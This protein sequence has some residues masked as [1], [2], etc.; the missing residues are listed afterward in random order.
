MRLALGPAELAALRVAAE[1]S[2]R[3]RAHLELHAGGA[4][5]A[6]QRFLVGMLPGSYVRAHRHV[7][8]HKLELTACLAGAFDLLLFDD[9]GALRERQRL[10]TDGAGLSLVQIPPNTWHSLIVREG[11][12]VLLEVKLGPYELASDKDFAD[13]APPEGS[14]E[15]AD[16]LRWLHAAAAG[17]RY[18]A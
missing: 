9:Q 18:R 8:A 6:L 2:P 16:C 12:A 1:A 15:V 13:W 14:A 11:F 17:Q 3:R 10:A 5:D 7:Q 4:D